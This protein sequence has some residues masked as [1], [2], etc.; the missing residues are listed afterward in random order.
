MLAL[1]ISFHMSSQ[2]N[3]QRDFCPLLLIDQTLV[4]WE[5]WAVKRIGSLGSRS[6]L[7]GNPV[8]NC[9]KH[10]ASVQNSSFS[11]DIR[12]PFQNGYLN[13][14]LQSLPL[15][16]KEKRNKEKKKVFSCHDCGDRL[17]AHQ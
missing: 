4:K 5:A 9:A 8:T 15:V 17:K 1:P 7:F 2:E 13:R 11:M 6:L 3:L 14:F 16:Q 10:T 12:S